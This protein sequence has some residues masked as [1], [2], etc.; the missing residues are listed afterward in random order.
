VLRIERV[1]RTFDQKPAEFR[2]SVV[3]SREFDYV[4]RMREL[5]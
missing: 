5:T 3:D 1:A 4:S 2:I